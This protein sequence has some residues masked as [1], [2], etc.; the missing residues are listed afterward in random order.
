MGFAKCPKDE[1]IEE[2][3]DQE[4][5]ALERKLYET[6]NVPKIVIM[7][8]LYLVKGN[9]FLKNHVQL[10][11]KRFLKGQGTDTY[12]LLKGDRFSNSFS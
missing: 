9:F 7:L 2:A 3:N 6:S 12:F 5:A 4:K 1:K 11:R 10:L 8:M